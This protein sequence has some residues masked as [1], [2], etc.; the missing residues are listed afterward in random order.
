MMVSRM[1]DVA[2]P[3]WESYFYV[4]LRYA[5]VMLFFF[6]WGIVVLQ[7]CVSFYCTAKWSSLQYTAGSH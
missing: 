5:Y 7:C 3:P 6:N 2:L 1:E 4:M